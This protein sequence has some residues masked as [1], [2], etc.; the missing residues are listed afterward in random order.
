M[1]IRDSV[2]WPLILLALLITF[3]SALSVVDQIS[4]GLCSTHPFLG[5]YCLNSYCETNST[6][7]LVLKR[8]TLEDVVP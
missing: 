2:M 5:K 4:L 8:I 1:C 3:F 7:P 6:L